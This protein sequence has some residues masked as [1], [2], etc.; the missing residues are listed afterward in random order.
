MRLRFGLLVACAVLLPVSISAQGLMENEPAVRES[1]DTNVIKAPLGV[2]STKTPLF[3]VAGYRP[4]TASGILA[5]ADP[6]PMPPPGRMPPQGAGGYVFPSAGKMFKGWAWGVLGPKAWGGAVLGATWGTWVTFEPPEW[7]KDGTGWSKRFGTSLA[8]NAA[9]T[10]ALYGIS[11][12]TRQDPMY[13]RCPCSGFWPRIG[14]IIKMNFVARNRSGNAV[15][16][17]AKIVS[18]FVG[19]M[20]TRGTLY[21]ERYTWK[22]GLSSGAWGFLTNA[23]WNFV[24]EFIWKAPPW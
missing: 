22:D 13:Y 3:A 15:F 21:P 6:L 10:T 4:G 5:D 7:H 18:P 17:P 24:R 11:A 12:I 14:H 9:N 19:P 16:S 8:D 1:S 2:A 20:I 23:G